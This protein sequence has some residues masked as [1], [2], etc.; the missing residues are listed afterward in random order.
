MRY[1][2]TKNTKRFAFTVNRNTTSKKAGSNTVV[3]ATNPAQG[4]RYSFGQSNLTLTVR[5]AQA[6]QSFL[7][8]TLVISNTEV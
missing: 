7:N 4:G 8:D 1:S 5:E 2:K 6:L 3:I